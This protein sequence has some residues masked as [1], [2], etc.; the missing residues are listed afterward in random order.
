[1]AYSK[2][3]FPKCGDFEIS[4]KRIGECLIGSSRTLHHS[5]MVYG[6]AVLSKFEISLKTMVYSKGLSQKFGDFEISHKR[7]SK[8]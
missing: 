7:V 8:C 5:N 3:F 2:G 1:M 6:K 4:H